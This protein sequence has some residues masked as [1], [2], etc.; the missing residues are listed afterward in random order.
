MHHLTLPYLQTAA[1]D[2]TLRAALKSGR[3]RRTTSRVSHSEVGSGPPELVKLRRVTW[4]TAVRPGLLIRRAFALIN[5]L[6]GLDLAT[7]VDQWRDAGWWWIAAGFVLAQTPR[8][9]QAISTL[10]SVAATIPLPAG[11]PD[12]AGNRLHEPRAALV[13]RADGDQRALLPVP[14]STTGGAVTAGVIDSFAG[15]AVQVLLL[16]LML[17]FSEAALDLNANLETSGSAGHLIAALVIVLM[18]GAWRSS[19]SG[20]SAV[21]RRAEYAAGGPRS[22]RRGL[23][24]GLAQTGLPDRR[25]RRDGT[26]LRGRARGLRSGVRL[27]LCIWRPAADQHQRQPVRQPDP[28]TGRHRCHRRGA[29]RRPDGAR[30]DRRGE[31]AAAIIYRLWTF[32]LP[33]IWGW[34]AMQWLRRNQYSS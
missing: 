16:P 13:D 21:H 23:A 1:F 32:Y 25:R 20:A 17:L 34:F 7:V 24:S 30:H 27:R 33:P 26:A 9:T 14:G 31:F 28:G 18:V 12:A 29:H 22:R 8:F 5:G 15:N 19:R 2:S 4:G 11:V 6:A 3:Y 10:G